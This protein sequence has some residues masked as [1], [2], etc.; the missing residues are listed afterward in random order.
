MDKKAVIVILNYNDKYTTGSLISKIKDY[1]ALD[2][3]IV[4]DNASTDNSFDYLKQV[5]GSLENIDVIKAL[6]NGGY[7]KGNNLGI[8]H[9]IYNY[10]PDY[11]FVAN[12]DV[13]ISE[14]TI[15]NMCS[16]MEMRQE[17][18]VLAPIVHEGFNVWKLP[19]FIGMIESLFLIWFNIDKLMI[20]K[21]L[22]ES[23]SRIETV[24]VVEGSFFCI[25]R[26]DY[27]A[28]NGLDE[29]TF[30][31]YE[32]NILAKRIEATGK[33]VGV[34]TRER[35]HH[36]HSVSIKKAFKSSKR[37]AFPNFYKSF[38]IYNKY[39]LKTNF[40]QD[41]LFMICYGIAYIERFIYDVIK[42]V[43]SVFKRD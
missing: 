12:P 23:E 41:V 18:A 21:K 32:E 4:V 19:G 27:E 16:A 34:M 42:T 30:L 8:R 7:A 5:Y 2:R 9:A 40:I 15:I 43:I 31:Y 3:I 1:E 17:Y 36:Y 6:I 33:K 10:D 28:V 14:K 22:I 37:R 25:R 38:R 11:I 24:G 35:Y 20:K 39:Y 29:R 26:T 13:E